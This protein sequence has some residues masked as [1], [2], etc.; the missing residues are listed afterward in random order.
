MP[1][2][3]FFSQERE[4]RHLLS[5]PTYL[6][7]KLKNILVIMQYVEIETVAGAEVQD[8]MGQV[9]PN[10][11]YDIVIRNVKEREFTLTGEEEPRSALMVDVM[12]SPAGADSFGPVRLG[13][14]S[15]L[16]GLK[17][18]SARDQKK[19]IE[20][21]TIFTCQYSEVT[22]TGNDGEPYTAKVWG[23]VASEAPKSDDK[24]EKK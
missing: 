2:K 11:K 19:A 4:S 23:I 14:N 22:R 13:A 9:E 21:R 1:P 8:V 12:L 24:K 7:V 10:T 5:A 3:I 18:T 6:I 15:L 16:R 17:L 20:N